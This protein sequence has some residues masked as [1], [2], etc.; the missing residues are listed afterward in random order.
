MSII[1]ACRLWDDIINGKHGTNLTDEEET[2]L[3]SIGVPMFIYNTKRH[4]WYR[5]KIR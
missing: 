2:A 4:K 5:M 1:E 3:I